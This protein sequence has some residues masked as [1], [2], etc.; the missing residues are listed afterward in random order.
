MLSLAIGSWQIKLTMFRLSQE[1]LTAD[2]SDR[3]SDRYQD[4]GRVLLNKMADTLKHLLGTHSPSEAGTY[5]NAISTY[6]M[7]TGETNV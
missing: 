4:F 1:D 5:I 3:M 2:E 6:G 7:Y